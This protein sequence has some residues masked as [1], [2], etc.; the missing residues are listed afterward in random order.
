MRSRNEFVCNIG[1]KLE[2]VVKKTF[3][4]GGGG[5]ITLLNDKECLSLASNFTLGRVGTLPKWGN[6]HVYTA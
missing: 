3:W 6:M 1:L 5:L 2:P 4:D